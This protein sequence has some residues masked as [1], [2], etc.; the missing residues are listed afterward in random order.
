M[1]K[2]RK[3]CCSKKRRRTKRN[4]FPG[5]KTGRISETTALVSA[6]GNLRS[7]QDDLGKLLEQVRKGVHVNP[8]RRRGSARI[9]SRNV[10]EISYRH[11]ADGKNYK[12][13]FGPGVMLSLWTADGSLRLH[14]RDG[15]PLAQD[16]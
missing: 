3:R 7:V 11:A 9:I 10:Y 13:E 14:N 15:K 8:P 1:T 16:M 6:R 4:P 2:K 5:V 12:H